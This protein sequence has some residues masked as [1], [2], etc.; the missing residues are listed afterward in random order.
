[1][2]EIIEVFKNLIISIIPDNALKAYL[3]LSNKNA[4]QAQLDRY[5]KILADKLNMKYK[6]EKIFHKVKRVIYHHKILKN[7]ENFISIGLKSMLGIVNVFSF[8]IILTFYINAIEVEGF[9]SSKKEEMVIY[10]FINLLLTIY[11]FDFI[12]KVNSFINEITE[13]SNMK[14]AN[15]HS[16]FIYKRVTFILILYFLNHD[17]GI[18]FK[19][20]EVFD[21]HFILLNIM[22]LLS[23]LLISF[24]IVAPFFA[25]IKLYN[26]IYKDEILGNPSF[27]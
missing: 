27:P 13:N 6:N 24:L 8:I 14:K 20:E 3:I 26:E 1:M 25:L 11:L 5:S 21:I 9:F 12:K 18:F 22:F 17:I 19:I 4:S 7:N 10:I 15:S 16:R 2:K 23:I